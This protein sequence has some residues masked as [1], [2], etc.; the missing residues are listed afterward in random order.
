MIN[1]DAQ[2][3]ESCLAAKAYTFN[4]LQKV[5]VWFVITEDSRNLRYSRDSRGQLPRSLMHQLFAWGQSY[6]GAAADPTQS[7]Y[8][9]HILVTMSMATIATLRRMSREQLCDILTS[10]GASKIAVVDVRDDD[11]VGGHI[12]SSMHV[13]SSTLDHKTPGLVRKLTEKEMV[14]FHCA[15]SQ[16]RGPSA[17]LRYMRERETKMKKGELEKAT[18]PPNI[19][20]KDGA[21]QKVPSE[22]KEQEIYVLDKGFV[23]WQEK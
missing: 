7:Y 22:G 13:P 4:G 17:A 15:L 5:R 9:R 23:G 12:R 3:R 8:D 1:G 11:H 6:T 21:V 2:C 14:V 16:Q 19:G 10:E 18:D 20:V